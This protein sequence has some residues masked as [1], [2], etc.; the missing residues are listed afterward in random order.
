M[1]NEHVVIAGD[2]QMGLAMAA[3][4]VEAGA[5]R[6]Q[7]WGPFESSVSELRRTRESPRLPGWPI[8]EPIELEFDPSAFAEG[9]VLVNAI[10]TQFMRSVW[11][12]IASCVPAGALVVST[13]KGLEIGSGARPSEILAASLDDPRICALSGPTIAAELIRRLP[14]L[15]VAASPSSEATARTHQ[16]FGTGWLRIYESDDLVG[17][18]L[19]GAVKNVIALAAGFCD[20][21]ELG[22]NAKSALLARGLVEMTRFGLALGARSDTFFGVAGV[23][24]LATTCFSPEGRNRSCGEAIARG[25]TLADYLEEQHCVV[26]GVPTVESV[27]RAAAELGLEMPITEMVGRIL[28][29][30]L[31]PRLAI[32]QLMARPSAAEGLREV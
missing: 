1:K 23:G 24:D 7:V 4:A 13:A 16:A 18:E 31:D 14:A 28:F 12:R 32:K 17:V 6:V 2:G 25:A 29:D 9:T 11:G 20:G 19:A 26:E 21:L 30:D 10:P 5:G 15:M 22:S 8:P 3:A 27:R